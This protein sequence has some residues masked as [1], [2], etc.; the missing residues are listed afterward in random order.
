MDISIF[1]A[2]C[3]GLFLIISCFGFLLNLNLFITAIEELN[4]NYAMQITIGCFILVIGIL[5]T[6]SHPVWAWDWR[7]LITIIGCLSFLKGILLI[8]FPGLL[9][10]ISQPFIDSKQKLLP[11]LIIYFLIGL[12]LCYHGFMST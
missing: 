12:F 9:N 7:V 1:L 8:G 10:T 11:F 2:K 4:N 3:A 5:I 6:V